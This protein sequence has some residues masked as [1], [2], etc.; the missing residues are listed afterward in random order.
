MLMVVW[1]ERLQIHLGDRADAVDHGQSLD[2]L[3]LGQD[4]DHL[5]LVL[6]RLL[7]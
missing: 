6:V 7:G 3:G 1:P 2:E 5:L 4:V